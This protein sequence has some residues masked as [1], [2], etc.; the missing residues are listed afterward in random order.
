MLKDLMGST[1]QR[2]FNSELDEELG[3]E[4]HDDQ[5]KETDNFRNGYSKKTVRLFTHQI[6]H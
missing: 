2:I 6:R 4:K 5:N 3:Y 1:I